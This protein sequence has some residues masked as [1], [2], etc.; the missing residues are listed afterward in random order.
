ML[1]DEPHWD[2]KCPWIQDSSS[3]PNN[4]SGVEAT[5]LRTERQLKKEAEPW[6]MAN[7]AQV[8][9]MVERRA[10]KKLAK[11]I[12]A[13]WKGPVWYV[14]HLVAPNPHSARR[15]GDAPPQI[16]LEF[17]SGSSEEGKSVLYSKMGK[18]TQINL[19]LGSED[20]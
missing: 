8:H 5:F 13:S 4:R 10:A 7:T 2:T 15:P 16:S 12:I 1:S 14:S 9:E 20:H 11:E 3:P 6:K 18:I 17:R 19:R